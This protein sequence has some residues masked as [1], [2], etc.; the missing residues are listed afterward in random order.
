M[1]DGACA[2]DHNDKTKYF[3]VVLTIYYQL[4]FHQSKD[5]QLISGAN[6][7]WGYVLHEMNDKLSNYGIR[8]T[9]EKLSINQVH[10]T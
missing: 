2:L 7:L 5:F 8:L 1:G 10:L 4:A 3:H 6:R 9:F